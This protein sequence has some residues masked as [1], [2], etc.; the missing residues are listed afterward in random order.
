MTALGCNFQRC[1]VFDFGVSPRRARKL[2]S[3]RCASGR[4]GVELLRSDE[5]GGCAVKSL[6]VGVRLIGRRN[7]R[8]EIGGPDAHATNRIAEQRRDELP[9]LLWRGAF[10]HVERTNPDHGIGIGEARFGEPT[11]DGER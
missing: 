7:R 11:L 3:V 6:T 4:S 8:K 1:F 2:P 10:Q 9:N 5:L